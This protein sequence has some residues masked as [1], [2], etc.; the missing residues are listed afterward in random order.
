MGTKEIIS[1]KDKNFGFRLYKIIPG[2]PLDK[3]G[4]KILD[5]FIIPPE[6]IIKRN[7]SF[8]DYLKEKENQ[9]IKV[10]IFS[11]SLRKIFPV[12]IQLNKSTDKN[13]I[14]GGTVNYENYSTA[15]KK[16]LHVIKV[17]DNSFSK[18][19][20]HLDE[21]NDYFIALKSE[22]GDFET[23][24]KNLNNENPLKSFSNIIKRN[25]GKKC[26]FFIYNKRIGGRIINTIIP[27]NNKFE[28]GCDVAFGMLHEIP[29][30][31]SDKNKEDEAKK[32][33]NEND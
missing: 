18:E 16:V 11:V 31:S 14:L 33:K 23:L 21:L 30:I 19:T 22:N 25:L 7:I 12:E 2:G 26:E 6:E 13:G 32:L 24:N 29:F 15:F 20:L 8:S 3:A 9:L 28:L 27:N 5:Y 17:K 1:S 4:L 10:N